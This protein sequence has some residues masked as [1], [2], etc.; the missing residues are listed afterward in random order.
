MFCYKQNH[1]VKNQL[2]LPLIFRIGL[3]V[4]NKY[5]ILTMVTVNSSKLANDTAGQGITTILDIISS[6]LPYKRG[7]ICLQMFQQKG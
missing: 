3:T 1:I 4:C 7:K 2:K 6:I 5:A